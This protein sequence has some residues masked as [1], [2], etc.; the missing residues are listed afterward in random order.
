MRVLKKT[1]SFFCVL[2]LIN[3][4]SQK[5]DISSQV[6]LDDNIRE[7]Y[8]DSRKES[9][10]INERLSII[11]KAYNLALLCNVVSFDLKTLSY[12]IALHG[13]IKK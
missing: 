10:N 8:N 9:L 12:I 11:N 13:K 4:C 5:S 3:S 1:S 2:F 7:Y 6:S